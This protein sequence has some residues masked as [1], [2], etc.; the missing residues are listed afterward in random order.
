[1]RVSLEIWALSGSW[2]LTP[3]AG[4]G[5]FRGGDYK[6]RRGR[7]APW[8]HQQVMEEEPIQETGREAAGWGWVLRWRDW[9][10]EHV[11]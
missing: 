9:M 8:G 11:N 3:R 5:A 10:T 7:C 4:D 6:V 1:M 2:E